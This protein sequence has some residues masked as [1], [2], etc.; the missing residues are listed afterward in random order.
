MKINVSINLAER[1]AVEAANS[2]DTL[3]L[4][5]GL[6]NLLDKIGKA[7]VRR[8]TKEQ[9]WPIKILEKMTW[10]IAEVSYGSGN[11]IHRSIVF[12]RIGGNIEIVSNED[13]NVYNITKLAYFKPIQK[14]T[15]MDDNCVSF[16]PKD[17]PAI[18]Y[19]ES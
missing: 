8:E 10:Y 15:A 19:I 11:P 12:H 1:K 4:I 3:C 6:A 17:A 14:L 7:C 18:V 9:Q 16:M 13:K 2:I 5:P